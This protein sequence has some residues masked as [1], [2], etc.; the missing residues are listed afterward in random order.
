MTLEEELA[1]ARA[2]A[3]GHVEDGEEIV[4]VV[5]AEPGRASASICAPTGGEEARWLAFDAAGSR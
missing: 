3:D 4:G 2:A 1:A 5:P